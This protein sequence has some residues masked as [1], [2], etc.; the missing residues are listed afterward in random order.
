M[1]YTVLRPS[2]FF[3]DMAEFY[4]MAARG[5][6]FL[7]GDGQARLNPVH[8]ADLARVCVRN[9][10][11]GCKVVAVGGPEVFTY[12]KIARLALKKAGRPAKIIRLPLWLPRFLAGIAGVFSN[13]AFNLISFM[14][15]A[16]QNDMVAPK[17]GVRSLSGYFDELAAGNKALASSL[18]F[19]HENRSAPGKLA[20]RVGR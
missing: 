13:R 2:G 3:S 14:S 17:A 15:I 18:P 16:M 10:T 4:K 8:G 5:R 6:I 19:R 11:F 1:D 9:S 12:E 20:P 7:L